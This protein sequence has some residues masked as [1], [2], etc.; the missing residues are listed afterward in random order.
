MN[1][2]LASDSSQVLLLLTI[3]L[4][5]T[6][7]VV[8]R[9]VRKGAFKSKQKA[10]SRLEAISRLDHLLSDKK[11]ESDRTSTII[12]KLKTLLR[13]ERDRSNKL[14]KLVADRES[15]LAR[16][17]P[18]I[19]V[20]NADEEAKKIEL[21]AKK[22][23]AKAQADADY[24]SGNAEKMLSD[25]RRSSQEM[26]VAA[27]KKSHVLTTSG[28]RT[29]DRAVSGA[30]GA[31]GVNIS[32]THYRDDYLIPLDTIIEGLAEDYNYEMSAQRLLEA[33]KRITHQINNGLAASCDY[34]EPL[35][36]KQAIAFVLD[37]FNVKAESILA[38]VRT[39]NYDVMRRKLE[40]AT[41][42][43]NENGKPFK[44]A[45]ILSK[46][47][48]QHQLQLKYWVAVK[49]L[50][51]KDSKEQRQL[52]TV[53]V[54]EERTRLEIEKSQVQAV[55]VEKMILTAIDEAKIR[56]ENA[57]EEERAQHQVQLDALMDHLAEIGAK[58]DRALLVAEENKQ[59]H[60]Y[61][62]SSVGTSGEHLL[63]IGTTS[64]LSP[65]VRVIELGDEDTVSLDFDVYAKIYSEDALELE[66]SLH[67]RYAKHR[68]NKIGAHK[69]FFNISLTDVRIYLEQRGLS[70]QWTMKACAQEYREGWQP[71]RN[72]ADQPI[73]TDLFVEL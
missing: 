17:K 38:K 34:K 3:A 63:T 33:R 62:S 55:K 30:V 45:R 26:L 7:G 42:F 39:E 44:N 58:N 70:C 51:A 50:K 23:L 31:S 67:E 32:V 49:E 41:N 46:Y 72:I 24:I 61:L 1:T 14:R 73:N 8:F 16:L 71:Q 5:I 9:L 13:I 37:A 35:R 20:A 36:K 27:K 19:A 25:A 22:I 43:I 59:G 53:M 6:A 64:G 11:V 56:L 52:K 60:V 54:D 47:A 69:E 4:A 21:H 29:N 57:S 40:D 28:N 66:K 2:T 48:E 15:L 65:L 68:V 10:D 18:Y 12:D